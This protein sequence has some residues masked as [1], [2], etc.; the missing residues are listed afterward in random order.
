MTTPSIKIAPKAIDIYGSIF[1][2][3]CRQDNCA[4]VPVDS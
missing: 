2:G 4:K 1:K 3:I